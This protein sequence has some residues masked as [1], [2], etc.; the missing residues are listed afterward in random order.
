[1][2]WY[3]CPKC[4]RELPDEW[5][6]GGR[7]KKC[8]P[9]VV[10]LCG[11]TQSGLLDLN[12]ATALEL[13]RIAGFGKKTADYVLC[14]RKNRKFTSVDDLRKVRGIGKKTYEKVCRLLYVEMPMKNVRLAEGEQHKWVSLV[15]EASW[16][17][18]KY[19][20]KTFPGTW[21]NP[22]FEHVDA[23]GYW[24]TFEL[25]NDDRRQTWCVRHSDLEG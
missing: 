20:N 1:M 22:R 17:M 25:V 7:C 8:G 10:K 11:K 5:A 13:Q 9:V 15:P 19:L 21:R 4:G 14:Y 3:E 2:S 18:V 6:F 23:S 12:R 24:Y 16:K